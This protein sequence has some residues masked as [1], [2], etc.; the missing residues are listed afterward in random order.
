MAWSWS[1]SREAYSDALENL[2]VLPRK[3]LLEIYAE[4]VCYHPGRSYD[5][6]AVREAKKMAERLSN[7]DLVYLI[8]DKASEE[9]MCSNGGHECWVCPYGCHTV[10]F[11]RKKPRKKPKHNE[12]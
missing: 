10:P 1:H 8:W 5:M 6:R 12:L 9:R 2:S 7:E 4:W 11:T 3:T